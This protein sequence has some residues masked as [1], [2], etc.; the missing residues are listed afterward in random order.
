MGVKPDC[1]DPASRN[2]MRVFFFLSK[3]AIMRML[4][5][6][7]APKAHLK[8]HLLSV[9]LFPGLSPTCPDVKV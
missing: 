8:L 3:T 7:S 9:L 5:S 6:I 4:L 1:H 2:F